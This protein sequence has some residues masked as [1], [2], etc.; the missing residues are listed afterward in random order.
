MRGSAE[1]RG[2]SARSQYSDGLVAELDKLHPHHSLVKEIRA[3][4]ERMDEE[5]HQKVLEAFWDGPDTFPTR[6]VVDDVLN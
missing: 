5:V 4:G 1:C 6:V 2:G 3:V